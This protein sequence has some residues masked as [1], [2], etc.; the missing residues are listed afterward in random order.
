MGEILGLGVTHFPGLMVADETTMTMILKRT[1]DSPRFPADLR[2][3]ARWPEPMRREWGADGGVSSAREHRRRMIEGFRAVRKELDSF[4]P[5]VV[6][7]F[8]DDQYEN[9][10]EDMIPPFCVFAVPEMV[11]R[12]FARPFYAGANVWGD[13]PE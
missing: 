3:P 13:G 2:D 4:A 7:V 9:F 8:G 5:D 10:R 12:P 11:S 1:L 6:V